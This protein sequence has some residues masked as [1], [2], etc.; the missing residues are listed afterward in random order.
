MRILFSTKDCSWVIY[1]FC[2]R[3]G[4]NLSS[5]CFL[6][7]FLAY[8]WG[9]RAKA[10]VADRAW[11]SLGGPSHQAEGDQS[12]AKGM[13]KNRFKSILLILLAESLL[14]YQ[15]LCSEF[16]PKVFVWIMMCL[17]PLYAELLLLYQKIQIPH[18]ARPKISR[19]DYK[20]SHGP[21]DRVMKNTAKNA[22]FVVADIFV[23]ITN[24][25]QH[26]DLTCCGCFILFWY[27]VKKRIY[28]CACVPAYCFLRMMVTEIISNTFW[29]RPQV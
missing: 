18:I 20:C 28:M 14:G 24:I 16:M 9:C 26:E 3:F 6:C 29:I 2:S 7:F 19:C 8:A 25:L 1:Y 15:L 4:N 23:H 11:A 5:F 13:F 12:I 17:E 22:A 10:T 21:F 27:F